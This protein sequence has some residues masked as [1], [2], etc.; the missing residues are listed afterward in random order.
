MPDAHLLTV[1][2]P[3]LL[4][5]SIH[6]MK[7]SLA[8]VR[9]LIA[10]LKGTC[11]EPP[12]REFEQLEFE[13]NRMNNSLMQLLILYKIDS[14]SF[15]LSIDEHAVTDVFN[16]V[17]AQQSSLLSLSNIDLTSDC[18][19][20]LFCYCDMTLIVNAL[21]TLVNN[22]QRYCHRQ[23]LLTA[24]RDNDYMVFCIEDDGPGYPES[25]ISSDPKQ[26]TQIDLATG[27]TGLGLIF[28]ATIAKMHANGNNRGL[29]KIDND[30]RLGG[31]RF[32]LY[33]P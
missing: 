2:F 14:F 9:A 30:S 19:E 6:D 29:I 12:A 33:L 22:A 25:F 1:N 7:N 3:A 13:A 31:A 8:T 32:R 4:A 21:S 11:P 17:I 28:V 5:S 16:E 26:T 18:S 10:Q 23:I 24:S 15:N 27:S 20:D